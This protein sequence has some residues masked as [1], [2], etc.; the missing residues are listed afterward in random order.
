MPKVGLLA[1]GGLE[2]LDLSGDRDVRPGLLRWQ[3]QDLLRVGWEGQAVRQQ[4]WR[5]GRDGTVG[6]LGSK[7]ED[8]LQ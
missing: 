4:G 6:Q 8:S 7:G 1:L 2:E 5:W 3:Q